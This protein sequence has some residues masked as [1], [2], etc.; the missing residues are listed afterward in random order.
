MSDF[1]GIACLP[2]H[3]RNS[4]NVSFFG[5]IRPALNCCQTKFF[6]CLFVVAHVAIGGV[7]LSCW[8]PSRVTNLE[9]RQQQPP[10]TRVA[11]TT[12]A[13]LRHRPY[14][15]NNTSSADAALYIIQATKAQSRASHS[16]R[17][18]HRRRQGRRNLFPCNKS[19]NRADPSVAP[20]PHSLCQQKKRKKEKETSV[21][22][23]N[24]RRRRLHRETPS[25]S[26]HEGKD[27]R[28]R[29]KD[30]GAKDDEQPIFFR[31]GIRGEGES[32][33]WACDDD[34]DRLACSSAIRPSRR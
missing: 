9:R 3:E 10:N 7:A 28:R 12:M 22:G 26:T 6:P 16:H 4:K 2:R 31:S 11:L 24:Q 5:T 14:A 8:F 13:R 1:F 32:L 17:S 29:R 21:R 33:R 15:H 27:Q 23:T 19:P 34:V 18:R 30:R 20:N 25:K